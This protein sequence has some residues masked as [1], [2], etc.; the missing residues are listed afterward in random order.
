MGHVALNVHLRL[1]PLGRCRQ[2]NN[3]ENPWAHSLGNRPD[4]AAFTGCI[5]ALK[6]DN[7]S[8]AGGFDPL[9]EGAEFGL[10]CSQFFV[11]LFSIE[12]FPINR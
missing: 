4:G 6:D 2:G 1:F 7:N 3:P 5:A 8:L 11:V 9:L 10:Q 12:F